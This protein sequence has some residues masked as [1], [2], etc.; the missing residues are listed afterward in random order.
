M[1][2][3]PAQCVSV[4]LGMCGGVYVSVGYVCFI[5]ACLCLR[6]EVCVCA[7]LLHCSS[8][9]LSVTELLPEATRH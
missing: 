2:V 5:I 1:C 6:T 3:L 9:A 8:E 7:D 4:R